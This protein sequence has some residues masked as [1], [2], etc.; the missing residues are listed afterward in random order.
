MQTYEI[1]YS[2][3]LAYS[4]RCWARTTE[5]DLD[6]LAELVT[7]KVEGGLELNER[8]V[9]WCAYTL[10]TQKLLGRY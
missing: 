2:A 3:V 4:A 8:L 1:V 10:S 9:D 6:D 7:E 5:E